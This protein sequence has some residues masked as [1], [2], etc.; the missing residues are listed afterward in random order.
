MLKPLITIDQWN[1][2]SSLSDREG[3][4][5]QNTIQV[6]T[7]STRKKGYLS[8]NNGWTKCTLSSAT[9]LGVI[10]YDIEKTER[11]SNIYLGAD[12]TKIY[13][14]TGYQVFNVAHDSSQSG[15]VQTLKEYADF[16]YYGQGSSLGRKDLSTAET[17]DWTDNWQTSNISAT[18]QPMEVTGDNSATGTSLFIGNGQYV[19][20]WDN[21]TFTYNALE[22]DAG[23]DIRCLA[24]FSGSYLAVGANRGSSSSSSKIFLW[25]KVHPTIWD[26]EIE[27]PESQI[28]AMTSRPGGLWIMAGSN[29]VSIYFCPTGSRQAIKV[30]TFSND[31]SFEN[32]FL[33]Y[34][35]AI[36][37]QG[38]RIYFSLS[39]VA[40]NNMPETILP[41]LYSFNTDINNLDLKV[42]Y[43]YT[44]I[45]S[46]T[47]NYYSYSVASVMG[48]INPTVFHSIDRGTTENTIRGN[49]LSND[50]VGSEEAYVETL[51]YEAPPSKKFYF[52]GFGLDYFPK[53]DFRS[54]SLY[55]KKDAETSY[56]LIKTSASAELIGF[57]KTFP[58][59]CRTIK[60]KIVMSGGNNTHPYLSRFYATGKLND[61]SR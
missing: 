49:F 31:K 41:A 14:L 51:T 34:P 40:E 2:G 35:N 7:N 36:T 55:Y 59:E 53:D 39:V 12:D 8:N 3:L 58:I 1:K 45:G 47:K 15:T 18:W 57:Y 10:V 61:D 48:S 19:A 20:K 23:W 17:S 9:D 6:N 11:D 56:T 43:D 42:E 60:F 21:T 26:D 30:F 22:L 25:N 27:I 37:A 32:Y 52:D 46:G 29:D 44:N 28:F 16:L 33:V 54:Y 24:S 50:S 13:Y 38:G 4:K 5:G